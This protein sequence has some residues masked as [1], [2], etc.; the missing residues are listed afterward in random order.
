MS[1]Y[2]LT[3]QRHSVLAATICNIVIGINQDAKKNV[4]KGYGCPER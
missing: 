3:A 4:T 1:R 2:L